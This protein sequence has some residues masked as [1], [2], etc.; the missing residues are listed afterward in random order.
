VPHSGMVDCFGLGFGFNGDLLSPPAL[1]EI[2]HVDEI[3]VML[4]L[5][6]MPAFNRADI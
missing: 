3:L 1:R 6:A 2:M 4:Q 5:W